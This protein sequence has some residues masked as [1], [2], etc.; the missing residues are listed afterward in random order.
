MDYGNIIIQYTFIICRGYVPFPANPENPRIIDAVL[1][2]LCL[3]LYTL[4]YASQTHCKDD[5]T[6]SYSNNVV[7]CCNDKAKTF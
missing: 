1:K 5:L 7:I 3:I 2:C 6:H 4:K